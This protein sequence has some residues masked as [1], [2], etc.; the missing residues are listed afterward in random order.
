MVKKSNDWIVFRKKH[1]GKGKS[2][3]ELSEMYKKRRKSPP[4][5]SLK[6]SSSK[7]PGK[8]SLKKSSS[9]SPRKVSLKKSS[10]KSPRKVSLK[11][12]SSKSPGKVSLKKSSSKSPR[13]VS[14]KKSSSK[15]QAKGR[16]KSKVGRPL[17]SDEFYC[18]RCCSVM[19]SEKMNLTQHNNRGRTVYMV[20]GVCENGHSM[21]K[22]IKESDARKISGEGSLESLLS[23][24]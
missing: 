10:S 3:K 21:S 2:L 1:A 12:S 19:K 15:S 5:V 7:S 8:V 9:K 16:C 18:L 6:K 23:D 24:E 20:K 11:K 4:K 13:K 17:S 22:I 14:L